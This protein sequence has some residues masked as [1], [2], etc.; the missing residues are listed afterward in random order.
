MTIKAV[1][2]DIDWVLITSWYSFGKYLQKYYLDN[3]DDMQ[4]FFCWEFKD[5]SIW[6]KDLK[7]ILKPI[8]EKWNWTLWIEKFLEL[9]FLMDGKVDKRVLNLAQT[10]REKGIICWVASNQEKYRKKYILE[11]MWF[12]KLFDKSYFSCDLWVS[13]PSQEYYSKMLADLN[14]L[15]D[16]VIFIDDDEK[17]VEGARSI[18][19]ESILYKDF[20]DIW[21][22][23][24]KL[25][26]IL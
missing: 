7:E 15:F 1:I 12:S 24:D 23:I 13:K 20:S 22:L 18:G 25:K 21:N 9:W 11:K 26:I 2:F 4:D 10:L 3:T 5:T 16:E 17:N 19:I 8:L 14:L 6:K